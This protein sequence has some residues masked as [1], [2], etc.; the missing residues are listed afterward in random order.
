MSGSIGAR[1]VIEA[2]YE[3][4]R[5]DCATALSGSP[6]LL[7]RGRL[8]VTT[9]QVEADPTAVISALTM[10]ACLY[11]KPVLCL[12]RAACLTTMLR[13]RQIAARLVIGYRLSP[14]VAHS[15]V[16]VDGR[17]IDGS[18][19]YAQRLTILHVS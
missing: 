4:A 15:W 6:P 19:G 11:W 10:A 8:P 14:F 3:L 7:E 5:F 1:Q 9:A 18:D 13:R 12:Q 2:W 17:V 16:E